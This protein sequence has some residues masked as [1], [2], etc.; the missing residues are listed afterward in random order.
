MKAVQTQTA[1]IL[2]TMLI[3]WVSLGYANQYNATQGE[4]RYTVSWCKLGRDFI[5]Y[6]SKK[7]RHFC[8]GSILNT[9]T[10][11]TAAHCCEETF[12]NKFNLGK[13]FIVAGDINLHSESGL[14]QVRSIKSH[15]MHPHYTKIGAVDSHNLSINAICLLTLESPL[16]FNDNVASISIDKNKPVVGTNITCLLSGWGRQKVGR[17]DSMICASHL[18]YFSGHFS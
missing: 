8:G 12:L 9:T 17:Y 13:T 16:E 15:V 10:I 14:K 4:F 6:N 1:V 2:L 18:F 5:E 3:C 7:C 11:I